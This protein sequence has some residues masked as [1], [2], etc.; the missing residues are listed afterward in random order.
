MNTDTSL[1]ALIERAIAISERQHA[2]QVDKAGRPYIEHP[3]RVMKAMSNDAERIVA[4]LHDVIEDTDFTLDQLA[5][6][7]FPGYILEALDSV[8][9]RDGETYEAFVARAATNPI[10][11]RVKYADL[12]DN[13][14]LSRIAAPTA[15]DIAR[16]EKYHRAMAQLGAA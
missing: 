11:R 7:G 1:Q 14:D 4:I 10:S 16:T 9:R 13:A 6:E 15:A 5:A 2:G 12:Q 8:T 3:L